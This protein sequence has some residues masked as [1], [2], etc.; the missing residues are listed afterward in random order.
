MI[1]DLWKSDANWFVTWFN[2]PAYH[3]LYGARDEAEAVR[4]IQ[5]LTDRVFDGHVRSVLD[6]GCGAGRHAAA[7]AAQ[8]MNAVG[9]DLSPNSIQAARAFYGES[10]RLRFVHGDMRSLENHVEGESFDAVSSLF[11]SMGYF[12]ADTDLAR[13]ITGVAW[14]LRPNGLFI[15]DFLNPEQVARGLVE[16]EVKEAGGFTFNIHRR[17]ANGWIE[18]SIQYSDLNGQQHHHVER[19]RALSPDGWRQLLE[20][21]GFVI[22]AHYGDYALA[23]WRE[24]APRSILVARKISC[25]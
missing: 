10:D 16:Q 19:V 13:T 21:T 22:E 2:T 18:K 20:R 23:P 15:F 1:S 7:F 24:N 8:G 3:A 17:I 9:I 11:T 6:V 12:E 14:T 5:A 25:G 4:F